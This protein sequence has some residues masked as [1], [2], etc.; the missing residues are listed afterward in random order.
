[1]CK[2]TLLKVFAPFMHTVLNVFYRIV[3]LRD[4]TLALNTCAV[5][6]AEEDWAPFIA[7]AVFALRCLYL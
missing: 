5:F 1:M 2:R 4:L 6:A 7:C 3:D